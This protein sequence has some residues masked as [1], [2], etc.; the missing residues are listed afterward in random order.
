MIAHL[1]DF[2]GQPESEAL[3]QQEE[4]CR[5]A[6]PSWR[7]EAKQ[8]CPK[9]CF[10]YLAYREDLWQDKDEHLVT[11]GAFYEEG[12]VKSH[13]PPWHL[14]V[15]PSNCQRPPP[16]LLDPHRVVTVA[17]MDSLSWDNTPQASIP[18]RREE[19]PQSWGPAGKGPGWPGGTQ[20]GCGPSLAP[21]ILWPQ[22]PI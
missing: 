4:V 16:L 11:V 5:A 15:V 10:H 8:L 21:K 22:T 3:E 17:V 7:E 14:A 2:R 13:Q 20:L 18:G 6:L 9:A 12:Q 1:P 19:S